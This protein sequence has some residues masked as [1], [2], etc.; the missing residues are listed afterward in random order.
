[1]KM[2]AAAGIPVLGL[3][4]PSREEL[5]APWGP[6]AAVARTDRSFR[7]ILHDPAYDY[8]RQDCWMLD[9]SVDAAEGAAVALYARACESAP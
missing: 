7:Q 6:M 9:L 3:F 5:Y 1:M 2:A 4:G 8:R